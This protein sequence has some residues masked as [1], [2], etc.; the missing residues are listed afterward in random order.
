MRKTSVIVHKPEDGNS[1]GAGSSF[2]L[3]R[4]SEQDPSSGNGDSVELLPGG[5]DHL[6]AAVIQDSAMS[7][8][9]EP[10]DVV[11][12][13]TSIAAKGGD[14]AVVAFPDGT[15]TC[16]IYRKRGP[17]VQ[18]TPLNPLYEP[19]FFKPDELQWAH[20]VVRSLSD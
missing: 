3:P 12:F 11:V 1:G 13:N 4:F 8:K 15:W 10:G 9:Y 5:V 14:R 2:R 7:P 20:P 18:L 6:R 17:L 16:R 19:F